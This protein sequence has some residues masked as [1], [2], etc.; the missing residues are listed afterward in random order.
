MVP[1]GNDRFPIGFQKLEFILKIPLIP[2]Q[3]IICTIFKLLFII[4]TIIIILPLTQHQINIIWKRQK[5]NQTNANESMKPKRL[6]F[7]IG[8]NRFKQMHNLHNFHFIYP[9]SH[10]KQMQQQEQINQTLPSERGG[11]RPNTKLHSPNLNFQN[12]STKLNQSTIQE[13]KRKT[14]N[15]RNPD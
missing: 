1:K 7:K 14:C 13:S 5:E 10:F 15:P 2:K 4:I 11:K 3:Y 6:H 9:N 12:S 8:K